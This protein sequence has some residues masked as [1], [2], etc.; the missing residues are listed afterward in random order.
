MLGNSP[1]FFNTIERITQAVGFI[2]NDISIQ[3]INPTTQA[4]KTIKVPLSLSS[5][6]KW[7]VRAAEDPNA[8][9]ETKQRHVQIVLPRMAYEL[10]NFRFDPRRK[11]P[12]IN[13]RVASSRSGPTALVQLNP[14]PFLFEYSLYLQCRTLSDSYSIIEQILTFFSPDYVVPIIDIPEMNINRDIVVN[15]IGCSH[16]DK[17]EG[18]FLDSRTIMWQFDLEVQAYIYAPIKDK[19]VITNSKITFGDVTDFIDNIPNPD[20]VNVEANPN[21]GNITDPYNIVET[22][23]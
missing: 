21:T 18:N 4:I 17:Y 9:D 10:T 23:V 3:R 13:Y 8:G 14:K 6:E 2:F 19:P 20:Y 22:F 5:K 16:T 7:A 15:M 12:S 11:L 1:F